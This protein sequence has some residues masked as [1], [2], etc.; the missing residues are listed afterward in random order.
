MAV[1]LRQV[2]EGATHDRTQ[3]FRRGTQVSLA[4]HRSVEKRALEHTVVVPLQYCTCR[5]TANSSPPCCR[6]GV[7]A[8]VTISTL[9]Q[10]PGHHVMDSQIQVAVI[11]A[12]ALFATIVHLCAGAGESH[13]SAGHTHSYV[14]HTAAVLTQL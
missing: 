11:S 6:R 4:V 10:I 14:D 7:V 12:H 5:R 1:L 9:S 8:I 13:S 2:R 3:R